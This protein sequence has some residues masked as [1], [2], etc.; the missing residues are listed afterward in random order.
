MFFY[1][2]LVLAWRYNNSTG[3]LVTIGILLTCR[4]YFT[5][6]GWGRHARD[7]MMVE[8]TTSYVVRAYH[9]LS[10]E[11]ESRSRRCVLDIAKWHKLCQCVAACQWFSP[12]T[13]VS[14]INKLTTT[15]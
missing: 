4:N 7:R 13:P 6:S 14:I 12:D 9:H 3:H 11:F 8:F 15:I 1:N 5:N 10:C 2:L